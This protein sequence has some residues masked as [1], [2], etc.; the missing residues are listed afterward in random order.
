LSISSAQIKELI[1]T[2]LGKIKADLVIVGAD[3]ETSRSAPFCSAFLSAAC[4]HWS[5]PK[6]MRITSWRG[7]LEKKGLRWYADGEHVCA[8]YLDE[9]VPCPTDWLRMRLLG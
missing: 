6:D 4:L 3:S 5:L 7:Q 1:D 2:A 8:N 9:V